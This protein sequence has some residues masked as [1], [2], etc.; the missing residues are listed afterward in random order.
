MFWPAENEPIEIVSIRAPREGGDSAPL[1]FADLEFVSIRAPREGGDF[2]AKKSCHEQ[3]VSIR[4]P[5]EGGDVFLEDLL[6]CGCCFNPRP[7]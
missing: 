6:W 2:N 3:R 5:R 7:P 4:A 1:L